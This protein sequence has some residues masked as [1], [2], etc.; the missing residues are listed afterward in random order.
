[1]KYY[2]IKNKSNC[3]IQNICTDVDLFFYEKYFDI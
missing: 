1:M 2:I 3:H